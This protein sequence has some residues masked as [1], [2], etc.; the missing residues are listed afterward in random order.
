MKKT[1]IICN[2][3]DC[4]ADDILFD[5][6]HIYPRFVQFIPKIKPATA[7][8]KTH[9]PQYTEYMIVHAYGPISHNSCAYMSTMSTLYEPYDKPST[10]YHMTNLVPSIICQI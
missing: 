5:S 10:F 4:L 7:T 6:K 1:H 3:K 9:T 8:I 2:S